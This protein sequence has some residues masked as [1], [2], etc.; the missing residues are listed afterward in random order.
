MK[1]RY[2]LA[3]LLVLGLALPKLSLA[4][5]P[6]CT[7]GAGLLAIAAA[8]LGVKSFVIASLIGAFSLALAFW[9]AKKVPKTYFSGQF[10]ALVALL[11]LATV[12][13]LSP[14]LVEY[15]PLYLN[16]FG[17]YGSLLHSTYTINLYY[18]GVLFGS[19]IV[20][21]SPWLSQFLSYLRKGKRWPFQSLSLTL[22]LLIVS[23][24]LI[25]FI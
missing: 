1:K 9:L 24:L 2:S 14:L 5:C 8:A 17:E 25:Q 4:H 13:P 11:Y 10:P 12:I 21:V 7:A 22:G 20:L 18:A 15:G 23:S 3:G 16:L 6:L 19:T